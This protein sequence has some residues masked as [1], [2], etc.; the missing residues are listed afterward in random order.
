[1]YIYIIFLISHIICSVFNIKT[2]EDLANWKYFKIAPAL[3]Q[4]QKT[5]IKGKRDSASK[6]NVNKALD[7][8]WEKKSLSVRENV[9]HACVMCGMD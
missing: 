9:L 3:V 6:A 8:E 2:I 4:L 1:M 5:E 7:K